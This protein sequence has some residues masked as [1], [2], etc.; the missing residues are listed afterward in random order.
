[1]GSAGYQGQL[2]VSGTSSSLS[3]DG[4]THVAQPPV[5][6]SSAQHT[7][8]WGA[9]YDVEAEGLKRTD[10]LNQIAVGPFDGRLSPVDLRRDIKAL[11]RYL[12]TKIK[13]GK[14]ISTLQSGMGVGNIPSPGAIV[15]TGVGIAQLRRL[16]TTELQLATRFF[17]ILKAISVSAPLSCIHAAS[18]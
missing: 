2:F 15:T 4:E 7:P 13:Y 5:T 12:S 1:V 6:Q 18:R 17:R 9:L 14:T 11:P 3:A 10:R 16:R 8:V